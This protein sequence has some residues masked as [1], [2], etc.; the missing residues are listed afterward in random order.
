MSGK[1]KMLG[2]QTQC[3]TLVARPLRFK[4]SL[5]NGRSKCR[6]EF[7]LAADIYR[8][9]RN[10][11][12]CWISVANLA[13][14]F[15]RDWACFCNELRINFTT[16]GLLVFGLILLLPLIFWAYMFAAHLN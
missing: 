10:F 11:D 5:V 16:R 3:P 2:G 1:G 7:S 14:F 9:G 4:W 6:R 12:S 13:F 8:S 15:P